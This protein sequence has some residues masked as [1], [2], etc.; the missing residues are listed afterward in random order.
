MGGGGKSTGMGGWWEENIKHKDRIVE[1]V[2]PH[3]SGSS[4][5][6]VSWCLE[7]VTVALKENFTRRSFSHPCPKGVVPAGISATQ[8]LKVIGAWLPRGS[9]PWT[10]Q[11]F[12]NWRSNGNRSTS[13]QGQQAPNCIG[14]TSSARSSSQ[15]TRSHV[16]KMVRS[17]A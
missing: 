2:V 12:G 7:A 6:K 11:I 9:G 3:T 10:H 5:V 8:L 14:Q 16:Y 15:P 17:S 4:S 13:S 1:T